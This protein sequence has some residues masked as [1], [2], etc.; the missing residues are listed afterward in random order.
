MKY[1]SQWNQDQWLNENLFKSKR[2]GFFVDVGAHDGET[3]SNTLFF[4]KELGWS[5]ICIEPI[6]E[7]FHQ[8]Q[9]KRNATCIQGCAYNR[10][11]KIPFKRIKGYSEMLSG[12]E[13][14]YCQKH[15]NRIRSE[16]ASFGG[17]EETIEVDTFR[18]ATLFEKYSISHVDYLSIDTEG[19]ELQILEGIDFDKVRIDVIEIEVNYHNPIFKTFFE[20]N[21]YSFKVKLGGDDVYTK[22]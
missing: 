6:P 13:E 3:L 5:G 9:T 20:N 16:L 12:I 4:E 22:N 2:N 14:A 19:S 17:C 7:V 18:L 11:G 21:G 8:L 15:S 10:D 1:Y